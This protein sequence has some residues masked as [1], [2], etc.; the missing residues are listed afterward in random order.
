M[1][2]ALEVLLWF[3]VEV[4]LWAPGAAIK[5]LFGYPISQSGISE[6]WIGLAAILGTVFLV[7]WWSHSV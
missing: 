5:R 1:Q 4:I 2:V 7:I 3:V 6:E